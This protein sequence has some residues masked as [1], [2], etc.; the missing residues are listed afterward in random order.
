MELNKNTK[1]Y[2]NKINKLKMQRSHT[3]S[4]NVGGENDEKQISKR[5]R[6]WVKA[7]LYD[8]ANTAYTTQI[9]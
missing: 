1:Q 6:A 3:F 9:T 4:E 2:Q 7:V 5:F 8:M